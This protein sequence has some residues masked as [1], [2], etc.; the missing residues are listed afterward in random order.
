VVLRASTV[1]MIERERH[2]L[3]QYCE[4]SDPRRRCEREQPTV[5]HERGYN[6]C[7]YNQLS[8]ELLGDQDSNEGHRLQRSISPRAR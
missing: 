7:P 3:G 1:K 8:R 5:G 2:S 4:V 6:Q